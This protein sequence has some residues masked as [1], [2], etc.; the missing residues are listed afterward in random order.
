MSKICLAKV[1]VGHFSNDDVTAKT[2]YGVDVLLHRPAS[3]PIFLYW[4]G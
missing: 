4:V 3:L 1:L 2:P